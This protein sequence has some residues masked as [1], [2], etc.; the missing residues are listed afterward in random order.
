MWQPIDLRPQ[1]LSVPN[2]DAPLTDSCISLEMLHF[3]LC[4]YYLNGND[5][6]EF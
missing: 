1:Y 6:S 4:Y 2:L 3:L 5:N